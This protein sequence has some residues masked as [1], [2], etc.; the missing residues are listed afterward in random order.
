MVFGRSCKQASLLGLGL[1]LAVAAIRASQNDESTGMESN[2]TPTSRAVLPEANGWLDLFA[3][4]DWYVRQPEPEREFT[5]VLEAIPQQGEYGTLQRP[6]Y[7]RLGERAIYTGGRRLEPLDAWIGKAV[8]VRGK[9]VEFPLEGTLIQEIWPAA[10]RRASPE[11][12]E[13]NKTEGTR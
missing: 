7:Y 2:Q 6:A 13:N 5:G 9:A 1:F 4:E 8:I 10:V 11:D 3:G 12:G